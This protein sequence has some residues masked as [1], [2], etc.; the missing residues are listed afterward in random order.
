MALVSLACIGQQIFVDLSR[1]NHTLH[2]AWR[3]Q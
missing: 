2:Q 1:I 3:H